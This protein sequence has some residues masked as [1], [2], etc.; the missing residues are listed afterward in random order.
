MKKLIV[1][2]FTLASFGAN[3]QDT[4]KIPSQVAKQIAK[5]LVICD[6][7]KAVLE[8]TKEQLSLTE[9][10]VIFKDSIIV[11]HV[12]KGIMYEDRI[13]NEQQKFEVQ[14]LWIKDLEKQNKKLRVKLIITK[15]TLGA[16]IGTLGYFYIT[17]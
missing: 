13:K 11:S 14:G 2:F 17:K 3:A 12:K 15:F 8:L 1:L 10:T 16:I 4:I 7:A 9:Q 5:D 6:S